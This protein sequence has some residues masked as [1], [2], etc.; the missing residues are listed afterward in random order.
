MVRDA[1]WNT[2]FATV[3]ATDSSAFEA[4]FPPSEGDRD[5]VVMESDATGVEGG[6][7][8]VLPPPPPPP[9]AVMTDVANN[10]NARSSL[11]DFI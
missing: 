4:T 3:K 7:A 11:R 8:D 10:I 9:Q 1:D 5:D 2:E 6:G